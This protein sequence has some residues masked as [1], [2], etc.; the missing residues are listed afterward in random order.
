MSKNLTA[1]G[2]SVEWYTPDW[3]YTILDNE[4]RF[5]LDPCCISPDV[6]KCERYYTVDQNG[7]SRSWNNERVF[8][9]PPYGREMLR[10]IEKAYRSDAEVCVMLLPSYTGSRWFHDLVLGKAVEVRFISGRV[11]F[12]G[13]NTPMFDSLIVVYGGVDSFDT[14]VSSFEVR[15]SGRSVVDVSEL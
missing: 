9:N 4:F 13:V 5:T 1:T 14:K 11:R 15:S 3:L 8:I 6:S 10:W 2:L 12:G 7:L